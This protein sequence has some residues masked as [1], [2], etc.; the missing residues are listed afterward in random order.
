MDLDDP[1]AFY[2][3]YHG[4]SMVPAGI[5]SADLCLVSPC[6]KLEPGQRI[7]LRGPE[8]ARR[9]AGG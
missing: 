5:G 6:A 9:A 2:A 7:W 3:S 8:G 1:Q 4:Y